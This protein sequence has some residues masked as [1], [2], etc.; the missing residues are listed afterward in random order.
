MISL[1]GLVV[2]SAGVAFDSQVVLWA[3]AIPLL[4]ILSLPPG[5]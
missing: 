5:V 4:P 1:N 2:M 3:R